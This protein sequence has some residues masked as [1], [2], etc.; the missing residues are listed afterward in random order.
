MRL[1]RLLAQAGL[2]SRRTCEQYIL[3]GRVSVDGKNITELGTTVCPSTQEIRVDGERVKVERKRYLLL[4]KP[5]G[6]LCTH[7]DPQGRPRAIDLLPSDCRL[8]TVGRLDENSQGLLLATNDGDLAN[9]LA[10]PRFQVE[11][12]YRV[13]V[14]GKPTREALQ[15]LKQGL[16]FSDGRFRIRGVKRLKTQG[17]SSFL[18]IRLTE[19]QNREIRRLFARIGHK[20]MKLTRVGFGPLNLGRLPEGRTRPLKDAELKALLE[21]AGRKPTRSKKTRKTSTR[22]HR[23][24]SGK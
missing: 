23:R 9:R 13:Q 21:L 1:Q 20:V 8:F 5:R 12:R 14:A 11:R 7:R 19:G 10:H 4:N 24:K 16:N 17:K 3:D 22:S 2:G 6:Y 18:E 15:Q